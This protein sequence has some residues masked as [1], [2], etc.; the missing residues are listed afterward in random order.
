MQLTATECAV[1]YRL[2]VQAPNVLI[3][4]PLLQGV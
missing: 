2:V 4:G 1:L 3:N